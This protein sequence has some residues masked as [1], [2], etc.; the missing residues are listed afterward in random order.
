MTTMNR[1]EE[2]CIHEK[3]TSQPV[4]TLLAK[5]ISKYDDIKEEFEWWLENRRYK[6]DSS[7]I[8]G[9]YTAEMI[10]RMVPHLDSVG[11]YNFLILLR[12][13]PQKATQYIEDGF[14]RK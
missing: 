8:I 14:P 13:N 5:K 3:H 9:G 11:V 10:S 4:A 1:I 2:Y 7:L 12:E 6:I